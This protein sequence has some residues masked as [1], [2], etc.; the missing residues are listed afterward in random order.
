MTRYAPLNTDDPANSPYL[1][2]S[3]VLK[4]CDAPVN[5]KLQLLLD[6]PYCLAKT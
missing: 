3:K 5:T 4:R 2:T 6:S 1:N